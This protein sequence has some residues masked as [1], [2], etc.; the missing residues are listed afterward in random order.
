VT[1]SHAKDGFPAQATLDGDPDTYWTTGDGQETAMLE[2]AL[3]AEKTFNVVLLQEHIAVG[4][5]IERFVIEV[6]TSGGWSPVVHGGTVG[7]KRLLRC[8]DTTAD[9][10]RVR[11]EGSRVA[12]TLSQFG[13]FLKPADGFSMI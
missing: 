6:H 3:G 13:L 4:Q 10:V 9:K 7:Y 8:E 2:Y 11:I 1:A 5:R 12:P